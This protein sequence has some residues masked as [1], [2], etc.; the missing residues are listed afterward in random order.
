VNNSN[1]DDDTF[2]RAKSFCIRKDQIKKHMHA[3]SAI[4]ELNVKGNIFDSSPMLL[5]QKEFTNLKFLKADNLKKHLGFLEVL[6]NTTDKA[7]KFKNEGSQ[8]EEIKPKHKLKE[9]Q[10]EINKLSR[11]IHQN[12]KE[13]YRASQTVLDFNKYPESE[14]EDKQTDEMKYELTPINKPEKERKST[15]N[16]KVLKYKD[17]T[18]ISLVS[19][20]TTKLGYQTVSTESSVGSVLPS[21]CTPKMGQFHGKKSLQFSVP[22]KRDSIPKTKSVDLTKRINK[23]QIQHLDKIYNNIDVTKLELVKEKDI[24][25][26]FKIY[27]EMS[28]RVVLHQKNITPS[29]ILKTIE[30]FKL[31]VEGFNFG[32][33]CKTYINHSLNKRI[34]KNAEKVM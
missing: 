34:V 13:I 18:L 27:H 10:K 12:K 21:I 25:D 5:T 30:K 16:P 19:P 33:F 28:R 20:L 7:M 22:K 24:V 14:E 29:G 6:Q 17:H 26:Y 32:Q 8:K 2:A 15:R 3:L 4:P 31:K 9:L 1:K 23:Q 11:N